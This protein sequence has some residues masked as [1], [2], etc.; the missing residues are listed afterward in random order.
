MKNII[1]ITS[2]IF[3][4]INLNAQLTV[5]T[6]NGNVGVKNSS[7]EEALTINGNTSINNSGTRYL[8]FNNTW[9]GGLSNTIDKNGIRWQTPGQTGGGLDSLRYYMLYNYGQDKLFFDNN[10]DYTDGVAMSI[11]QSGEV[12]IGTNDPLNPLHVNGD[13]LFNS[14]VGN[15]KFGFP[16]GNG[17]GYATTGGGTVLIMN[18]YTNTSTEAGSS[19]IFT[20]QNDGDLGL[21]T[22]SPDYKLEVVGD[23]GVS[24]DIYVSGQHL[25]LSD[26][27]VKKD[28]EDISDALEK[29]LEMSPVSYKFK[30]EEY[31]ALKLS[32]DTQFGLIAQEV[33]DIIPGLVSNNGK[34]ESMDGSDTNLKAVNYVEIIP[35]LIS[36]IHEL[37]DKIEKKDAVIADNLK[38]YDQLSARLDA[39]EA[40]ISSTGNLNQNA[41]VAENK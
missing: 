6:N 41:S 7:P 33:E 15:L 11:K 5:D 16:T 14:N 3:F 17:F 8:Y 27:R 20:L 28:I 40:M 19:N 38:E 34:F 21:G 39:L 25:G 4:S 32:T 2:V 12:G 24:G 13:A 23:I 31:P 29:V 26:Q 37:N 1:F 9:T 22:T 10:D 36:A 30:T 35:F 18:S